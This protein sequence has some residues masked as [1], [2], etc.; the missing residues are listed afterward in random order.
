MK[1][2]FSSREH[3]TA[4]VFLLA[5]LLGVLLWLYGYF[6]PADTV[7][8][9]PAVRAESL[10]DALTNAEAIIN[11]SMDRSHRFIQL[12][13]GVQRLLGRRVVNDTEGGSTVYKLSD[14]SLTFI[15][16]TPAEN[17]AAHAQAFLALVD[18]LAQED[19]P[20]L[21]VQAPQKIGTGDAP[22]LPR[23]VT[24][25]GNANA[26]ELLALL[27]QS[28]AP[29]MDLRET[30]KA[31]GRLW[32]SYFFTTDH[33]WTPEAALL[34]TQALVERL[35]ESFG[36]ELDSARTESDAFSAQVYEKIFLGSQGKRTGSWY[37]GVDDL[38]VLTPD[39]DTS[40]TYSVPSRDFSISGPF[41]TSLLVPE[42]LERGDLFQ[43]NPYTVYSGGDY[44]FARMINHNDPDGPRI[45]LLRDSYSCA[46]APFLALHC[47]ELITVDP[48][49]FE[50]DL[51]TCIT[52]CD[53]DLVV[54]LYTPGAAANDIFFDFWTE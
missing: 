11:D 34:C 10:S 41:G 38:T 21:Y 30:L 19:I 40:F 46:L 44:A 9:A 39:Y 24:D 36:M 48:R 3:L 45:V 54:A 5:L 53:P 7:G 50:G 47:S 17:L 23:G 14:G 43:T 20:L 32:T 16:P 31:D 22:A 26:D 29:V 4:A 52:D 13:G 33:H 2:L 37:A 25:F 51:L 49:Y 28:G 27:T 8:M 12:Y 6:A 15:N 18:A 1:K 42:R 35:N